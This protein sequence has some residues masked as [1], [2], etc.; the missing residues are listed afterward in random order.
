MT[1]LP[2]AW[3]HDLRDALVG[4]RMDQVEALRSSL[5]PVETLAADGPLVEAVIRRIATLIGREAEQLAPERLGWWLDALLLQRVIHVPKS[6][7]RALLPVLFA[8]VAIL[9]GLLIGRVAAAAIMAL[10]LVIWAIRAAGSVRERHGDWLRLDDWIFDLR[11]ARQEH[12]SDEWCL[13]E[14]HRVPTAVL[15]ELKVIS[16]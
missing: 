15:V 3:L 6:R 4:P 2:R 12:L 5:P 9:L 16:R 10:G 13:L 14:G 8:V 1:P 7:N 11:H